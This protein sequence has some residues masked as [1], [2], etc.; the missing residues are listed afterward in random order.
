MKTTLLFLISF[1]AITAT[2]FAQQRNKAIYVEGLGSGILLSANYDFRFK[3][4]QDGLGMRIGIGGGNFSGTSTVNGSTT[5]ASAGVVTFPVLVNYLAGTGRFVFEGGAGLTPVYV[6]TSRVNS[7]ASDLI[8]DSGFGVTGTLNLGF[9]AQPIRNGVVF[10]LN[11]A[12][13]FNSSGFF[14][15]WAGIS[16]GYGFK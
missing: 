1:I 8:T 9:R 12:P 4:Q 15:A 5:P 16:L 6:T 3:P 13:V 14:P 7:T 10:R 2:T 11:W